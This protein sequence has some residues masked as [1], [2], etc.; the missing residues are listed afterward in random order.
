MKVH[1]IAL[2]SLW[3]SIASASSELT[4]SIN[5]V[6]AACSGISSEL[7]ELK[8]MAGITT[9]TTSIGTAASSIS[10]GVG[11]AKVNTD[12]KITNI[13]T[14]LAQMDKNRNL[15]KI[16][17][18]NPTKLNTELDTYYKSIKEMSP[19]ELNQALSELETKSKKLGNWRTGALATATATNIA[20]SIMS[21]TNT[22]KDDLQTKI[23]K[24]VN[25]VRK[26][27]NT[28]MQAHLSKTATNN[29]VSKA[30]KIIQ[31]CEAWTTVDISSINKRSTG[32]T[33]S[34]GIGAG[35]GLAG[36]I[37]SASANSQSV[38]ND[39]KTKEKNLNTAA[40][41]LAGGTTAASLSATIFNATQISAIKHAT[42]V[43]EKCEEALK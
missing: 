24:C 32:A 35:L 36:T 42:T 26:L 39:D 2:F 34:S 17:I 22:I 18:S 33:V 5:N 40:N 29:E 38:R 10:L 6:H 4:I 8:K 27:S 13:Q 7:S 9:A 41:M 14:Q 11:L 20:G 1:F 28:R 19:T 3:S 15:E 37:T 16:T 43:A 31:A 21:G 25:S 12:T 23:D 30:E